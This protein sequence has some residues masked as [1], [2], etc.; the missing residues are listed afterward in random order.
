MLQDLECGQKTEKHGKRERHTVKPGLWCETLKN[1]Q[2]ETCTQQDLEHCKKLK[3]LENEAQTV[4]DQ[5]YGE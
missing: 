1:V 2:N 5:E 4:Y 3:N